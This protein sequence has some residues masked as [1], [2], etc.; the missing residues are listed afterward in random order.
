MKANQRMTHRHTTII[1]VLISLMLSL[2]VIVTAQ[3]DDELKKATTPAQLEELLLKYPNNA[4]DIVPRL[5]STLVT[6]L[7]SKPDSERFSIKEIVPKPGGVTGSLSISENGPSEFLYFTEYP[8]DRTT[9]A[10][11][12]FATI[13]SN[14]KDVLSSKAVPLG[15]GSI[16]RFAGGQQKTIKVTNYTFV[17]EGKEHHRLTFC[18]LKGQG[19]VYLRG[20]GVVIAPDGKETKLGY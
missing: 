14:V 15:D 2:P 20:K 16:Y 18:L 5:E 6:E 11:G 4:K 10:T 3:F 1:G 19:Y 9:F 17:N 7:R 12:S 8:Q 13:E